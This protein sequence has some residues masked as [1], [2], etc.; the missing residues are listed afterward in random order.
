MFSSSFAWLEIFTKIPDMMNF[1]LLGSGLFCMPLKNVELCSALQLRY[2]WAI[3]LFWILLLGCIRPVWD[4]TQ[5]WATTS[6]VRPFW[7]LYPVCYEVISLV[8]LVGM[9]LFLVINP[10][11][12]PHHPI[13]DSFFTHMHWLVF[14]SSLQ[15][16]PFWVPGVLS[17]S[18]SP[19]RTL[20]EFYLSVLPRLSAPNS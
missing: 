19:L 20:C 18:F 16:E 3:Q 4:S 10:F 14:Y 2:L 9:A 11:G 6:W 17:V 5:P 8:W 12:C 15:G 13:F 7:V 1:I